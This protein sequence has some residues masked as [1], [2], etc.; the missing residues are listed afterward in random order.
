MLAKW[1]LN[2]YSFV[3]DRLLTLFFMG[4]FYVR[5]LHGGI[6]RP[7]PPGLFLTGLRY[8]ADFWQRTSTP[9]VVSGNIKKI[10]IMA[11]FLMTSAYFYSKMG[12][13]CQN[14]D[15]NSNGC[16]FWCNF[17][18]QVINPSKESLEAVVY[19]EMKFF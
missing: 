7:P 2:Q 8:K 18:N 11:S 13:F 14:L 4:Y 17:S 3:C 12:I 5:W 10:S 6:N 19:D 16:N 15:K 9:Y 1:S